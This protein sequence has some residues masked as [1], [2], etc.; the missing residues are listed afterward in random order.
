[1]KYTFG[2]LFGIF[3]VMWGSSVS[4]FEIRQVSN[5]HTLHTISSFV[6]LLIEKGIIPANSAVQARTY[7]NVVE[8]V[9]AMREIEADT[10]PE[11][12][13]TA[14]QLIEYSKLSFGRFEDIKGLVLLVENVSEQDTVLAHAQD[15]PVT[16]SVYD[17]TGATL[18]DSA[19][20]TRCSSP[21][22][23]RYVLRAGQTRMFEVE[24]RNRDR[25]LSPGTYRF[26]LQY[27]GYGSDTRTVTIR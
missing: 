6:D 8:R 26:E 17:D 13:I 14:S 12:T 5:T 1:M 7:A 22:T 19:G 2:L 20:Q 11:L 25:P 18:F 21:E 10:A 15:C 4:A 16:Y 9:H 3:F 27:A 23:V 24:H